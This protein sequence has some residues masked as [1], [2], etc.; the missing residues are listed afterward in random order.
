M[1]LSS[2]S[3]SFLNTY[4]PILRHLEYLFLRQKWWKERI[5]CTNLKPFDIRGTQ[6]PKSKHFTLPVKMN[7]IVWF[8]DKKSDSDYSRFS[9]CLYER[10]KLGRILKHDRMTICLSISEG[11]DQ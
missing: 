5:G 8:F 4:F 10:H 2:K 6:R 3:E 1:G 7:I 9:D 11:T